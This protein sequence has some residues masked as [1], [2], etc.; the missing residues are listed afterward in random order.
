MFGIEPRASAALLAPI[1]IPLAKKPEADQHR[2]LVPM[3]GQAF[4]KHLKIT[5]LMVEAHLFTLCQG[6]KQSSAVCVCV[7]VCVYMLEFI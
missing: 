6:F 1:Y 5:D 7:C 4:L 2:H 3:Q